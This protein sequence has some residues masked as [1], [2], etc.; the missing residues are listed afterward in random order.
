MTS[1]SGHM[2]SK[3]LQIWQHFQKLIDPPSRMPNGNFGTNCGKKDLKQMYVSMYIFSAK[4]HY[5]KISNFLTFNQQHRMITIPLVFI[6]LCTG[7][8]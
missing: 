4:I 3:F 2:E 6:H 5:V 8:F 7:A 1:K